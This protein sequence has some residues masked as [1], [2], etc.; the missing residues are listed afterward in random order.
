MASCCTCSGGS[1]GAQSSLPLI[2]LVPRDAAA[3]GK[4]GPGPAGKP[5]PISAGTA[6]SDFQLLDEAYIKKHFKLPQRSL[7]LDPFRRPLITFPMTQ[8]DVKHF[9]L[10]RKYKINQQILDGFLDP[11]EAI[12]APSVFPYAKTEAEKRKEADDDEEIIYILQLPDWEFQCPVHNQTIRTPRFIWHS[13]KKDKKGKKGELKQGGGPLNKPKPWL[14]SRHTDF[15]L[16]SQ[17]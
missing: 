16:L 14:L 17:W 3:A 13:C 8:E 5:R 15:D 4:A 10:A 1:S 7:Y 2:C 9:N 11:S 6:Q 12:S